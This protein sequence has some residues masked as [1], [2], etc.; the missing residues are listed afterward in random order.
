MKQEN[1]KLSLLLGVFV[2]YLCCI[3][4]YSL[5]YQYTLVFLTGILAG[6]AW[7]VD[8]CMCKPE[9]DDSCLT[10][11]EVFRYLVIERK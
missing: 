9:I 2:L 7:D 11:A 4:A 1:I 8:K 5:G 6:I 3:S 10:Y